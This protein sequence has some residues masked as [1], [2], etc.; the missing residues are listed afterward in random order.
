[1]CWRVK[2]CTTRVTLWIGT[3]YIPLPHFLNN[4]KSTADTNR[5]ETS[6]A[7]HGIM[8]TPSFRNVRLCVFHAAVLKCKDENSLFFRSFIQIV[9]FSDD[10]GRVKLTKL[11]DDQFSDYIN[12]S[13]VDVSF[14]LFQLLRLTSYQHYR[15]S[16]C[17]R[18]QKAI[19]DGTSYFHLSENQIPISLWKTLFSNRLHYLV[20]NMNTP[21]SIQGSPK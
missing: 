8:L 20:W 7:S 2:S 11:D 15:G 18:L 12:A 9:S 21:F 17:N 5:H 16:K 6:S 4:S 1:M 19:M 13:F 10:D 14:S 3:Y